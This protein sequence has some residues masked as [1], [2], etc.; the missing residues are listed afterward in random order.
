MLRLRHILIGTMLSVLTASFAACRPRNAGSALQASRETRGAA[1]SIVNHDGSDF[2]RGELPGSPPTDYPIITI[3]AGTKFYHWGSGE[4]VSALLR[5]NRLNDG[6]LDGLIRGGDTMKQAAGGGY[7][8]SSDMFDSISFGQRLIIATTTAPIRVAT[9][10]DF[11]DVR[12]NALLAIRALGI[13]G[14]R[15]TANW[16]NM[17]DKSGLQNLREGGTGDFFSVVEAD[18]TQLQLK[19]LL[20]F[21]ARYPFTNLAPLTAL[22]P[23]IVLLAQ[24]QRQ[25]L[26]D[27]STHDALEEI[28]HA[29][30]EGALPDGSILRRIT[31]NARADF[32]ATLKAK[33]LDARDADVYASAGL[34]LGIRARDYCPECGSTTTGQFRLPPNFLMTQGTYEALDHPFFQSLKLTT[35][36]ID[37]W[38]LAVAMAS[39]DS[40]P[41]RAVDSSGSKF[42]GDRSDEDGLKTFV[43]TDTPLADFLTVWSAS[44]SVRRLPLATPSLPSIIVSGTLKERVAALGWVRFTET[45]LDPYLSG[46]KRYRLVFEPPTSKDYR[47]LGNL[48][49]PSALAEFR[50]A[51]S[52][53]DLADPSG[54]KAQALTAKMIEL[55]IKTIG[56]QRDESPV[57]LATL[58]APFTSP[59][60]A[61]L[62]AFFCAQL[63]PF[64]WS[65][66]GLRGAALREQNVIDFNRRET[67][68]F[69][70]FNEYRRNPSRPRYYDA[71]E[72]WLAATDVDSPVSNPN[73]FVGRAKAFF[74]RAD[75]RG[76][77][78][79][80]DFQ[81]LQELVEREFRSFRR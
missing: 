63:V 43:G 67:T 34:S 58:L 4:Q 28:I 48:I 19:N 47:A 42:P 75:V 8:V 46:S 32:I 51:E 61:L 37:P 38:T 50:E 10:S 60:D 49:P 39:N 40:M 76:H 54:V 24:G 27:A 57:L 16:L 23:N 80:R 18:P 13:G 45:Q 74:Q 9:V 29:I 33:S 77:V 2:L 66:F 72:F 12:S 70:F 14:L 1:Y 64:E 41:W 25:Q 56:S 81:Y 31:T 35:R 79:A 17:I 78:A 11:Q 53:G 44:N 21:D 65:T 52:A 6:D 20:S 26:D 5:T 59:N 55:A 71:P 7:Y 62:R 36:V 22:F 68:I 3:P 15:Y 30:V 73:A 69:G